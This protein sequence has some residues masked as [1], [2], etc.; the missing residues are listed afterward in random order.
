[1]DEAFGMEL[2]DQALTLK[3]HLLPGGKVERKL[4]LES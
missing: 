1:M 3:H 2:V 4:V